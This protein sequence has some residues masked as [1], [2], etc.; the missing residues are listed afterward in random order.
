MSIQVKSRRSDRERYLRH[1]CSLNKPLE[2][3]GQRRH[4]P[5]SVIG[6]PLIHHTNVEARDLLQVH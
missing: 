1:P 5:W 3:T 6:I 4:A 2:I